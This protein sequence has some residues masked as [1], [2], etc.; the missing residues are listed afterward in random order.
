V[1]FTLAG[2]GRSNLSLTVRLVCATG[3]ALLGLF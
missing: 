1:R 2:L 3:L